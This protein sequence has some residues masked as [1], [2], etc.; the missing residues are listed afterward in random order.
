MFS[1]S[2]PRFNVHLHRENYTELEG[3]RK[4]NLELIQLK[5]WITNVT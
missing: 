2:D 3:M 1:E 4:N 5:F